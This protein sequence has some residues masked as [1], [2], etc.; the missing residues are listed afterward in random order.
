MIQARGLGKCYGQVPAVDNLSF[1]VRPGLVTGFLGPNGAGKSTTMR[2]MLGLD[3]GS[4]RTLF[5]GQTY[6]ELTD[7]L[8]S[9][10]V[11][12]DARSVHPKRTAIGHLRMI[13]AGAGIGEG[14]V[15]DVLG[16]V[17]LADVAGRRAGGFSL[18][19]Q[20]RLGL[21]AAL[22]GDPATLILDEP[23]NGLDPE[24][25]RWL[26]DLLK[27]LARQGRTVFVSSH[28]LNEMAH[29]ADSLVVIG[30]GRLLAAES[31]AEFV[32]RNSASRIVA[33][34]DRPQ[35][36]ADMLSGNGFQ[37]R[38]AP[39]GAV[40]IDGEDRQRVAVLAMQAGLL[41]TE[42]SQAHTS[43]ED[44]FFQATADAARYRGHAA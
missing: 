3:H 17:G 8:R 19:M 11:M 6:A 39:D 23:A 33:R 21:A 27:G 22:L 32:S 16:M 25:V 26:R 20:Q 29:L 30:G 34:T 2:L 28:L 40:V 35:A 10:G 9:V 42:L 44:A 14:R 41:V 38:V 37:V 4:G 5:D 31:V 43:L 36:L 7:P 15:E 1:D 24:G 18:G 12:L 13:A